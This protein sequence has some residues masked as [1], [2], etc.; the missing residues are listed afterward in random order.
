MRSLKAD[1]ALHGILIPVEVDADTGE[2]LDGHHR[3]QIGEGLQLYYELTGPEDGPVVLQ[4]GGGLFGRHNFGLVNDGFREHFR[5]L[6]FDATRY[7]RG[8]LL[9]WRTGYELDNLGFHLY[10]EVNGVR[11]KITSSPVLSCPGR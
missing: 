9:Q 4:F 2:V 3:Q 11:T 8:V 5:L 1:I 7:D 10:R 6:S